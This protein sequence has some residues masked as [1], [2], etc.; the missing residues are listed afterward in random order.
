[1]EWKMTY[2]G[3]YRSV[4]KDQI[5]DAVLVGPINRGT[6]KFCFQVCV[7]VLLLYLTLYRQMLP[8][9]QGFQK[10]VSSDSL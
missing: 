2:V 8:I 9:S 4:E 1:M 3:D 5:L 7:D 6:H 10:S